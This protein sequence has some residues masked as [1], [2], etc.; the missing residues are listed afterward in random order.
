MVLVTGG[1]G[2]LG[3]YVIK[4]LVS[5]GIPVRAIRRKSALPAFIPADVFAAVQWTD[6]DVLDVVA[7]EEA[8]EGIDT[9]I[10]SAAKV[11]FKKSERRDMFRVN[12]EG[13]AN[14]INLAIEKNV[15]H[16]IHVSSVAA[17]GRKTNGAIV[18]EEKKW[19]DNKINTNYAISKYQ[20]EMEVWRGIGEGL[21]AVIVNPSTILGYGDWNSSSCAIFRTAYTE[22]PWYTSGVNGFVD[23]ED[24]AKAIVLLAEKN[25]S[26][27][28]FILNGDNWSFRQLLTTIAD[29]FG[30][31]RFL[32]GN[33]G[34]G[35]TI[36][37]LFKKLPFLLWSKV[38]I[39]GNTFV[40]R[41]SNQVHDILFE[42]RTGTRNDGNLILPDHFGQ[43][44][45]QFCSTHST[46]QSNHHFSPFQ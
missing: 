1:T 37:T 43:A 14:V 12:I 41:M 23:V 21:K 10:H 35:N 28:R 30:K 45:T 27:E 19:E 32:F 16:F 44:Y 8:M 31:K 22:F 25:I 38:T 17:L 5:R 34:I 26:G 3:A 39:V 20:A 9:V 11:S 13:T 40:V 42:V 46:C 36:Q 29:G 15:Q 18:T 33:A 24:V 2:F 4:E 7:L 6:G